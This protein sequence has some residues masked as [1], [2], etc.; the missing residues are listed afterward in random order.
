MNLEAFGT[1]FS[2]ENQDT[3]LPVHRIQVYMVQ[4]KRCTLRA[5]LED[6]DPHH[7]LEKVAGFHQ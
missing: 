2:S 3:F 6:T 1:V 4:P 5:P 7:H